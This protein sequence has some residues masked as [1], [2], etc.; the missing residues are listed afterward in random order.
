VL[1]YKMPNNPINLCLFS[2]GRDGD[3]GVGNSILEIDCDA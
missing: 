3:V 1:G 2:A